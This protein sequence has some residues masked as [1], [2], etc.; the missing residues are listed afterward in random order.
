M[1][2]KA[3]VRIPINP[4]T[5][6]I[7]SPYE[8]STGVILPIVS[9]EV[10]T[11]DSNYHHAEYYATDFLN[12]TLGDR[13]SRFARLQ[14]VDMKVHRTY[15]KLVDGTEKANSK[16]REFIKTV[17]GRAG[18]VPAYGA[19]ITGGSLDIVELSKRQRKKL[20][21]P[22]TF[23]LDRCRNNQAELGNFIMNYALEQEFYD[24]Y[25][26]EIE[27]FL[28][29]RDRHIKK[30]PKVQQE[31]EELAFKLMERALEFAVEP[32]MGGASPIRQRAI[33][34]GAP[35][36]AFAIVK[37][38]VGEHFQDYIDTLYVNVRRGYLTH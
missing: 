2:H 10:P 5:G 33:R 31:R 7:M 19:D 9:R 12:G 3:A 6:N 24:D 16:H 20:R 28:A 35:A 14:Q 1:N 26:V 29:I 22:G 4:V 13:A 18:Y 34:I 37:S 25:D 11:G 27:R 36:C 21:E 38:Y 17:L 8:I 30:N 32:L 15:H 23:V